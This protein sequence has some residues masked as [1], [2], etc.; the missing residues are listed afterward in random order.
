MTSFGTINA[1]KVACPK[2]GT[3]KGRPCQARNHFGKWSGVRPHRERMDAGIRA[4]ALATKPYNCPTC[5]SDDKTLY[6]RCNCPM[7][8]DGRDPR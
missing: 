5:G 4:E 2:C 6:I 8:P 1:L 7:C 3:A